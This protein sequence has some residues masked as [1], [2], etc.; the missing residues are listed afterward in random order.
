MDKPRSNARSKADK[1]PATPARKDVAWDT[2]LRTVG[3]ANYVAVPWST[4][5]QPCWPLPKKD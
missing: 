1:P 4:R 5:D 3:D 2:R